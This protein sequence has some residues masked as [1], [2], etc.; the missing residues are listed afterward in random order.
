M[1]PLH[2]DYIV[3][4]IYHTPFTPKQRAKFVKPKQYRTGVSM[5]KL[6]PYMTDEEV[7]EHLAEFGERGFDDIPSW[8]RHEIKARN[9]IYKK[10]IATESEQWETVEDAREHRIT[11]KEL[12]IKDYLNKYKRGQSITLIT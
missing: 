11:N 7:N 2:D 6:K 8:L 9:L 3:L 12:T 10:R 1:I 5:T 4:C